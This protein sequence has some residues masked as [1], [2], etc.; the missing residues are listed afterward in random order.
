MCR[1][2]RILAIVSRS[3]TLSRTGPRDS[4]TPGSGPMWGAGPMETIFLEGY[5]IVCGGLVPD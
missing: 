3:P 1:F 2:P 4:G 5:Y